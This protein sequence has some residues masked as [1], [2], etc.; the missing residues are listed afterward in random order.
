MTAVRTPPHNSWKNPVERV[1][2]IVNIALQSVGI[3]RVRTE[4]FEDQLKSCRNLTSIRECGD[5]NPGLE[6]EVVDAMEPIKSLLCT[7]FV[8]LKLEEHKFS[9][10]TAA[11]KEEIGELFSQIHR[12]DDSLTQENTTQKSIALKA[13]ILKFLETHCKSRHYLFRVKKC[14]STVCEWCSDPRLP[15]EVF[16]TLNH[17]PDP[18]P[19]GDHYEEFESIY[20]S[21]TDEKF[22]PSLIEAKEKSHGMPFS[23]TAQF[24]KNVGVVVQC[25]ECGKWRVFYSKHVLTTAHR[26]ELQ[27]IIEELTYTCGS[28]LQDIEDA[29]T[30]LLKRVFVKANLSK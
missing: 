7:L 30:D 3:M 11:S 19:N 6:A 16:S 27:R 5:K 1:M 8:Q 17:L 28:K 13:D 23:P 22:R 9:T 10:F 20:G 14:G 26:E 4:S 29:P 25:E 2:S 15:Q 24:A 21:Q 12:I 18:I